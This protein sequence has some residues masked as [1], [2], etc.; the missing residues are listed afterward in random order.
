MTLTLL[1]IPKQRFETK[2]KSQSGITLTRRAKLI[3]SKNPPIQDNNFV[4]DDVSKLK[5]GMEVQHQRFGVGKIET[6][7]QGANSIA[8]I[9][10]NDIGEKK[11]MLKFAKLKILG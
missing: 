8:T 3:R 11:I 9:H 4:P 7:V 1:S 6:I 2:P 5:E 10:F